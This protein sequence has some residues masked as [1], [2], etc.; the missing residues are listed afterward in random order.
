MHSPSIFVSRVLFG[1]VSIF[2]R[3]TCFLLEGS[4]LIEPFSSYIFSYYLWLFKL[5]FCKGIQIMNNWILL[6]IEETCAYSTVDWWFVSCVH[7]LR[8]IQSIIDFSAYR[9]NGWIHEQM[10]FKKFI[11]KYLKGYYGSFLKRVQRPTFPLVSGDQW[12][13][14]WDRWFCFDKIIGNF[15]FYKCKFANLL[16]NLANFLI[17]QADFFLN[18]YLLKKTP[19]WHT[20]INPRSGR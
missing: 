7:A 1:N 18:E 11:K 12:L 6:S 17:S 3:V 4:W 10:C 20:I 16:E 19:V 9:E 2:N 5:H 14:L 13:G 15:L 8:T